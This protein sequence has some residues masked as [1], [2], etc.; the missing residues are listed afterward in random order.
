MSTVPTTKLTTS[1]LVDLDVAQDSI[2]RYIDQIASQQ[3]DPTYAFKISHQD[4]HIALGSTPSNANDSAA[5]EF[6][7]YLA[8]ETEELSF[9]MRLFL[10]PLDADGCDVLHVGPGGKPQVYDFNLPCPTTCDVSS[11][12]YYGNL[13]R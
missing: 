12:L 11:P 9:K 6:R 3:S 13:P 1:N 5:T 10:V 8:L 2:R 4:I 7:V